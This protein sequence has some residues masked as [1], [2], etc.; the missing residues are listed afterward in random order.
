MA[1]NRFAAV[2]SDDLY[3]ETLLEGVDASYTKIYTATCTAVKTFQGYLSAKNISCDFEN[4]TCSQL[5]D[6]A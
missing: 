3:L 6:S 4:F 1:D 2:A 5:D